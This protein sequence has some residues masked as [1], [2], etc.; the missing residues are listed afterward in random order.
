MKTGQTQERG[1]K[2]ER[3]EGGTEEQEQEKDKEGEGTEGAYRE[4]HTKHQ[5][6]LP[7]T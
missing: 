5:H 1:T 7:I 6:A 3:Q 4:E 2:G